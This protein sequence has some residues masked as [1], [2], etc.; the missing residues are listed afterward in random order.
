MNNSRTRFLKWGLPRLSV[1]QLVLLAALIA[2]SFILGRVS[3][4]TQII[5]ISFV[6]LAS[7]LMG[8]W[9]GPIWTMLAMVLTDFVKVTFISGGTWSPIMAIG[10]AMA[11]L[12]YGGFFY[13]EKKDQKLS[14][15]NIALAVLCITV[16][17]NL[18]TNTL[19]LM[20]LFSH[21]H[22]W[23]V[24]TGMLAPRLMK[25][26]IFYPIQLVLTYWMLNNRVV[27]DLSKRLFN[28]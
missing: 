19:A 15:W 17:V 5:R 25:S 1:Q 7:S 21:H 22:S 14:W 10:V 13:Q 3:I 26:V 6:F 8:K 12:I 18:I 28:K 4:T 23:S 9:F 16:F 20:F 27:L 11:G 24:F 2:L